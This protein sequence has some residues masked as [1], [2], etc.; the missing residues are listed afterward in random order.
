M[1]PVVFG[2][3]A[4]ALFR[5][6]GPTAVSAGAGSGK[7]TALVELVLRLLDGRATGQPCA[8]AELAA[9]TFTDKAGEEL[10]ARVR[11]AVAERARAAGQAGDGAARRSWLERL[12]GLDRL[13]TGTIHGFCGRILREHAPE[14][15]LDPEFTVV[16]EERAFAWLQAAAREAVIEALDAGRPLAR[17]LSAAPGAGTRGLAGWIAGLVRERSTRGDEGPVRPAQGDPAA[18]GRAR[19]DLL[20]AAA[21]V[22]ELRREAV[23]P[24]PAALVEAVGRAL[25]ALQPGD[26]DGPVAPASLA[27]LDALGE[28]ARGKVGRGAPRLVAARD[29]LRTAAEGFRLEA[30]E[31]L[32]APQRAELAAL[33]AAAERRYAE[34]K[35]AAAA[36]DF[37]DLLL[38]ARRLLT[39][40]A[41]LR[42]ELRRGLRALLIDEYQDV[43]PVQQSIFDILCRAEPAGEPGP[44]LVAVGDLKQSIYRFRGADVSVFARLVRGFG[45]GGRAEGQPDEAAPARAGEEAGF[46]RRR[47]EGEARAMRRAGGAGFLAPPAR[48]SGGAA[49]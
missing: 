43:N 47:G 17:A 41:A 18:A 3:V 33:V 42:A 14:A 13:A 25:Q 11:A 9:I 22:L 28:A 46:A 37:D 6:E 48:S 45:A 15:G 38:E 5:L 31:V 32:A 39:R 21:A 27:R 12:H 34:R 4:E 30:A 19:R 2:P 1:S 23:L 16:D 7:T 35:R 20:Q 26:A 49:G 8:P 36:V 24:E 40:D 44:I 29:A 10:R